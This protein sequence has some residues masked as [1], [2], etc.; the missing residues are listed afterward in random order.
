MILTAAFQFGMGW[1]PGNQAAITCT[2][3][4]IHLKSTMWCPRNVMFVG[5]CW[6]VTPLTI[7]MCTMHPTKIGVIN[8][9]SYLGGT[10]FC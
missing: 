10:L 8:H 3:A 1:E 7:E 9:L 5:L 2:T 4:A 6:F